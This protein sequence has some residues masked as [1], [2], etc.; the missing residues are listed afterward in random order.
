MGTMTAVPPMAEPPHK[1]HA[2]S[3]LLTGYLE[4]PVE[5]KIEA[6]AFVSLDGRREGHLFRRMEGFSAESVISFR[7]GHTR[8]S[9]HYSRQHGWVTLA[10]AALEGLNVLDV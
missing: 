6:Q 2:E 3:D 10:T 1:F 9:G 4:R 5:L 8:V 7:S